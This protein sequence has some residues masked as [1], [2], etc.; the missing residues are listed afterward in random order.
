MAETAPLRSDFSTIFHPA[1]FSLTG[2]RNSTYGIYFYA[3][4]LAKISLELLCGRTR[5]SK[6]QL[7]ILTATHRRLYIAPD[8]W[9]RFHIHLRTAMR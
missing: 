8:G 6:E 1:D 3:E 9:D 2:C 4:M 5:D 7:I